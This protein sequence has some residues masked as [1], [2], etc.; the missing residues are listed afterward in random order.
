VPLCGHY[1]RILERTV[2]FPDFQTAFALTI[3]SGAFVA[4]L[5][6]LAAIALLGTVRGWRRRRMAAIES[7]WRNALSQAVEDPQGAALPRIGVRDL[8]HFLEAWNRMLESADAETAERLGTLLSLHGID[9]RAL[10]ML[11]RRSTRLKLAAITAAG[12]LREQRA[13][14]QLEALAQ[15]AGPITSF[16]AARALLRIDARRALD[17][18]SHA[19]PAREDWPLARLAS[20]FEALGPAVVTNPLITMLLRRPRPGLDRV[21]KLARFGQP[22][23]ISSIVRGWL[24]SSTDPDVLMAALACIEDRADLPWAIGAA[25]HPEWRVR[26]AAARAIGKVGSREELPVLLQLLRDPVWWV[27]YHAAHGLIRLEG[28][29]PHEL[30]ALREGARD[31][32][33]ADMLGQALAERRWS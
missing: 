30:E 7:G 29:Q 13:W 32:F 28:L 19:I 20:V 16:A 15:N 6:L 2:L 18:L 22:E 5:L 11:G 1:A 21:V 24:G 14:E 26:M 31:S 25:D 23:K 8:P 12:H 4:G 10:R 9:R 3:A 27:R 33:A 17:T